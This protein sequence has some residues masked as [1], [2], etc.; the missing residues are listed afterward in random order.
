MKSENILKNKVFDTVIA[1][2]VRLA[3]A[4]SH[5]KPVLL[6]DAVSTGSQNY[7]Q[8]AREL[9]ENNKNIRNK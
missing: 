5:G 8:L 1:R 3:E 2:N 4:P 6:Y 9:I 7:L